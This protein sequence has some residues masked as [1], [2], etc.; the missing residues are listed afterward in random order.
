MIHAAN[1]KCRAEVDENMRKLRQFIFGAAS[2]LKHTISHTEQLGIYSTSTYVS[3]F[4][5]MTERERASIY[6]NFYFNIQSAFCI[7]EWLQSACCTWT[8]FMMSLFSPLDSLE[9][10]GGRGLWVC[11]MYARRHMHRGWSALKGPRAESRTRVGTSGASKIQ[12]FIVSMSGNFVRLLLRAQLKK[13]I[14]CS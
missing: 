3:V 11:K 5:T 7:E 6:F 10:R 2:S 1:L 13:C 8:W 14:M 12:T 9:W 4:F